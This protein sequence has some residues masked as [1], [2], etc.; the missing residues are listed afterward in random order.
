MLLKECSDFTTI[1]LQIN[2][3]RNYCWKY[4]TALHIRPD[5]KGRYAGTIVCM[6]KYCIK[7][8]ECFILYEVHSVR[9]MTKNHD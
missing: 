6:F 8:Y 2:A 5:K 1:V 4:I 9:E 3:S 7:L